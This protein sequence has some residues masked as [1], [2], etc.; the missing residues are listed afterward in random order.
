MAKS[1]VPDSSTHA[2]PAPPEAFASLA[3]L[4]IRP[5]VTVD[6]TLFAEL[7]KDISVFVC[8]D[9]KGFCNV[10]VLAVT[11]NNVTT[12][13]DHGVCPGYARRRRL[14]AVSSGGTTIVMGI[15]TQTQITDVATELSTVPGVESSTIMP[16]SPVRNLT[17]ALDSRSLVQYVQQTFTVF[18]VVVPPPVVVVVAD[19]SGTVIAV[20][21][22]LAA[23]V[24][25][26]AVAVFVI[27]RGQK[28]LVNSEPSRAQFYAATALQSIRITK[29]NLKSS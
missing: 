3:S 24:A 15:V 21:V 4:S 6:S 26:I 13:C 27:R 5:N 19:N 17:S 22:G 18:V 25:A 16:N 9:V 20:A 28:P 10:S 23:V 7:A 8:A 11:V 2:T 12:Y 1:T 29:E 14:L